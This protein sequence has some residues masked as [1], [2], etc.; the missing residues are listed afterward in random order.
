[1]GRNDIDCD[2]E[3]YETYMKS[4]EKDVQTFTAGKSSINPRPASVGPHDAAPSPKKHGILRYLCCLPIFIFGDLF[5]FVVRRPTH[6]LTY[7]ELQWRKVV[8]SRPRG[9]WCCGISLVRI[10]QIL[11]RNFFF[12]MFRYLLF[13]ILFEVLAEDGEEGIRHIQEVY[14]FIGLVEALL[15]S[16]IIT[17][18]SNFQAFT[19][20]VEGDLKK[21]AVYAAIYLVVIAMGIAFLNL[22]IIVVLYAYLSGVH[23]DHL[24]EE[25]KSLPVFGV[26]A[27]ALVASV[28]CFVLWFVAYVF[29]VVDWI[30]PTIVFSVVGV[31][32]LFMVPIMLYLFIFRLPHLRRAENERR[33][34]LL[35]IPVTSPLN[36]LELAEEEVISKQKNDMKSDP[37]GLRERKL[38]EKRLLSL[39][40]EER[41]N[42][43]TKLKMDPPPCSGAH[44]EVSPLFHQELTSKNV[45]RLYWGLHLRSLYDDV[46][47]T[48]EDETKTV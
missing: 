44:S 43:L 39:L 9:G 36:I 1:M 3:S 22:I 11:T 45:E 25:V 13:N 24:H 4:L 46:A 35:G 20:N 33:K 7:P 32:L 41:R 16:M 15:L 12:P 40:T 37:N 28:S 31:T 8:D 34:V 38:Y 29:V 5:N 26:P 47:T 21:A 14:T 27:V 42:Y 23:K 17:P 6:A 19:Q 18:V 30:M 48:S 10:Y 2:D